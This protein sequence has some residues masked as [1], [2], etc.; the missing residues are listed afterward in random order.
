MLTDSPSAA[1]EDGIAWVWRIMEDLHIPRLS[2]FGMKSEDIERVAEK[3]AT[4]SSMKAN[5][6]ALGADELE[7][8]L[9]LA[10]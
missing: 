2:V 8:I 1:A 5:P 6:I 4:A 9:M 10:L 3:S 7:K